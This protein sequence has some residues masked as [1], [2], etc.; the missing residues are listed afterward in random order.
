MRVKV[1]TRLAAFKI[2]TIIWLD[3]SVRGS[4]WFTVMR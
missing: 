2:P 4:W 1:R 3:N